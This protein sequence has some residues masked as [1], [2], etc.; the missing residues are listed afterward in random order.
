MSKC[1]A[2]YHTHE[3]KEH[4]I[5]ARSIDQTFR[6]K[7]L[8]PIRRTDDSE[9]F[10]V[11]YATDS[12]EFFGGLATMSTSMQMVG[13]T[14][15]FIL[16]CIG[17]EDPRAADL[18]RMRDLL[19]HSIR[20]HFRTVIERLALSP[21]A[22]GLDLL[23]A[24]NQTTDASDYLQFIRSELMP[25][26][27][28]KYPTQPADVS[29]Y[30]YSAG[31]TFGL[32]TLFTQPETFQRYVLGSPATSY[33]GHHFGIDL[34]QEFRKQ[35]RAMNASV[36]MAVGELE[37]FYGHF[38]LTTGYFLLAKVLRS[39]PIPG[40]ALTTRV[41]PG[42]THATA[43]TAAFNHGLKALFGTAGSVPFWPDFTES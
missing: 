35:H 20:R 13:E 34:L 10:P 33:N 3:I 39:V 17:Y 29:Y 37:E 28:T 38:D 36:Y 40:L 43:W 14:P 32:F 21:L 30:G 22:A 7:V 25:F 4:L 5:R 16:V 31:G 8:L 1:T 19:T 18:L 6:V 12:D 42:E 27:N 41:F 2:S 23:H 9:R 15:R 24:V 26:I 11:L